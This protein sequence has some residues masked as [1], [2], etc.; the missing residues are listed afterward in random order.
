[1]KSGIMRVINEPNDGMTPEEEKLI[2]AIESITISKIYGNLPTN[3]MKAIVA[4][5]F[6]CG[7]RQS[8]VAEI[9]GVSESRI[10]QEVRRIKDILKGGDGVDSRGYTMASPPKSVEDVMSFLLH[11]D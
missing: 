2:G 11:G 4:L 5:H 10:S 9:L 8:V 1:M 3:R 6:E 7:Y